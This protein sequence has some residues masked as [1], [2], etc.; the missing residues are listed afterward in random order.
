LSCAKATL[1]TRVQKGEKGIKMDTLPY[2]ISVYSPHYPLKWG[3]RENVTPNVF[4]FK[5]KEM[6]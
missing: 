3:R 1:G 5:K 2:S 6:V 4:G